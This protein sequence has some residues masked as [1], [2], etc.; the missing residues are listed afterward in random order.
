[1]Q[2]IAKL[3]E[4]LPVQTG[5]GRNGTWKKQSIIVETTDSNYPKKICVVVWGDKAN[6]NILKIGNV[7]DIS[8][9]IESREFNGKWYTDVKAWK[10]DMASN[11]N[12]QSNAQPQ[13]EPYA[14][15]SAPMNIPPA[16]V[17]DNNTFSSASDDEGDLPF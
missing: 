5:E 4:V 9:D 12:N 10:I 3:I 16:S 14:A 1:M 6:E 13:A 7:L 2:L 17:F 8:I 11:N 15:T